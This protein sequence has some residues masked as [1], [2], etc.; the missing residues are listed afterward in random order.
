VYRVYFCYLLQATI[1]VEIVCLLFLLF[2][3]GDHWCRDYMLV[4]YYRQLLV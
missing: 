1:G 3:T 2:I 4:I